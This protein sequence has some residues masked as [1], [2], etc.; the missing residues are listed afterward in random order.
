[1]SWHVRLLSD[2]ADE[3][4]WLTFEGWL[5]ASPEHLRAYESVELAWA[6]LDDL[7]PEP[8]A[9][10]AP[11]GAEIVALRPR[12]RPAIP[13]WFGAAAASLVAAIA[14]AVTVGPSFA[15]KD[16]PPQAYTTARGQPRTLAL[17]DGTRVTLNGGSAITVSLG[18]HERRVVMA[19]AEA[20]FDVAH[21]PNRPFLIHVGD[22]EIH[23]VG[24]EFDV[25][26]R[27]GQVQVTVRRGVVEVRKAGARATAPLARLVRGQAL[28]HREGEPRDQVIQTDPQAAFAWTEGRL[29]FQGE[30]LAE[31]VVVLNRYVTTPITVAPDARALPVRAVLNLGPED[32][33]LQ[34]LSA[35]LPV[36]A[37][38]RSA[39]NSVRL[40]LRR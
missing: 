37:E 14:L 9:Q 1:M 3:R 15:P 16:P 28:T 10:A 35:F 2:E 38:R 13:A 18:K 11:A 24:T 22:R 21:D 30:S 27:A 7:A 33:M 40:S 20:V 12:R 23:V 34:S 39:P 17:A 5:A 31:A 6:E 29:I 19:D 25:L 32:E 26:H 8:A 4:D 36:K